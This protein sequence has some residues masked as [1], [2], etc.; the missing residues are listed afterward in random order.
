MPFY[1]GDDSFN[2]GD[3]TAINCMVVK[4]DLP[5]QIKWTLNGQPV[6]TGKNELQ[7]ARLSSKL[8]SLTI[9]SI[10]GRHRGTF[11]CIASN[12]AGTTDYSSDLKING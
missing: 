7:V 4:G 12:E 1:F 3:S 8:S 9:D 6:V 11:K 10:S 2:S 5:I